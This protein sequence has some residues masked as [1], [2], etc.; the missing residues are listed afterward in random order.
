MP[1]TFRPAEL[2]QLRNIVE[3]HIAPHREDGSRTAGTTIWVVVVEG[4]PYLRS[5]RGEAGRWYQTILRSRRAT[6]TAADTE[7]EC[8]I[9]PVDD[10]EINRKVD[11]ALRDKYHSRAA[12]PTAS[13]LKPEVVKTT[14]RVLPA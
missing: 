5:V 12:G 9:E 4:H 7:F 6:L 3:I 11:A 8:T 2:Q 10:A 1:T 14:M 13:M